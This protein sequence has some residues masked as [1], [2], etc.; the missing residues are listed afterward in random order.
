MA[1]SFTELCLQMQTVLYFFRLN[2]SMKKSD[3]FVLRRLLPLLFLLAAGSTVLQAQVSVSGHVTSGVD[4]EPIIGA[5]VTE[6]GTTNGTITDFD[7]NFALEVA[8]DKSM[9]EISYMG[10]RPVQ[11]LATQ[12][13]EITLQEDA[14]QAE[15]LVVTGYTT[16]RK[17]DLTGAVSV[18]SMTDIETSVDNNPMKALQGKIAGVNIS[19]DGSPSGA[20]TVRI[21]GI[22]T[23]NN[24]DPL[25]IIDGVPT[26]SGMHEL[27][28]ADI[29]SMQVLKDASSASIYG[30][31]AANGVII[32]TTKKGK[33]ESLDISFDANVTGSW[34]TTEMQMLNAKEY[35]EAMWR[36]YINDNSN[37]NSNNIGYQYDWGYDAAGNPVLYNIMLP[38]YLD[39]ANTMRTSDTD[40]F[41]EVSKTGVTQNYNLTV[42]KGSKNG[43]SYFSLGYYDNDGTIKNT[44]FERISAR[45]NNDYS[46]F[47]KILTIGEN[48]TVNHTS[49]VQAPSGILNTALQALPIIPVHTVDGEGWGGPTG[50]MNDRDNPV[51]ILDANKDNAYTYWRIF[52][53][54]YIDIQPI[55][56]LHLRSNFG[57][58]Y[59]NYYRRDLIHSYQAGK[60]SSDLN[61]VRLTQG[62][63]MKWNWS[64]TVSYDVEVNKHRISV[65]AGME[66]YDENNIDFAAYREGFTLETPEVMWPNL[67]TG[68]S[69]STGVASGYA[70]MSFF[71]KADYS[72]DNRYLFSATFRYD[73]SSRFGK[74][75]Q[76]A[77][78]PAFSAGWR[79]SQEDF[80]SEHS[81]EV[82]ELKLRVG[83]G[84]TGNQEISNTA[85]YRIYMP[86]YGT[87]DP[88]WGAVDGTAYDITGTGPSV[89]PSGFMLT[90]LAN[91][92]LK[93]ETTTQTNV[94]LD[95]GFMN[96]ALYGT[97]EYYYKTTDDI[98]VLP[99]YLGAIGEGGNHW[100]NGASMLN[101]GVEVSLGYRNTTPTGFSYE[102][103]ANMAYNQNVMTY[104]PDEVVNSY[105]G[106]GVDDNILGHSIDSYYGYIADGLFTSQEEID[107]HAE[108]TG[109]GLGRIKYRD[110]NE[111]GVIDDDDRTWL[112]DPHPD[113]NFGLTLAFGYKGFDLSVFFQGVA[114]VQVINNEKYHTDFW[115][116]QETG[117][118][119]GTRLLDAW[120]PQN[121]DS[122]IPALTMNNN[123]D[124]GRLSTYFI[125]DGSYL[126]LRN[127]QL[128]YNLPEKVLQKMKMKK[129]RIYVSAQNLFTIKSK[130]YTGTDPENSSWGYP[131]P[132][133]FTG[134]LS[135]SF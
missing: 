45:V 91:D 122:D 86:E 128:G 108:Q 3:L 36:A 5:F 50:S 55:K 105:G 134:G 83:W 111:D 2:Q 62:H 59:G 8:T 78:F 126:K 1:Q 60:L 17:A 48:L 82:S 13:G 54:A 71:A 127:I 51:R 123:N 26:K 89:L 30:S 29:E 79:I 33:G 68:Q 61:A 9:L 70:L 18:V 98:L 103:S 66:M 113:F 57:I 63:W 116:V 100:V 22:G 106:N 129:F 135:I 92:D 31:R 16:Q 132:L 101:Q 42:S 38:Y 64:N 12:A 23:L 120:S 69:T 107:N 93:W 46:F 95:F 117:S 53:N 133:T 11:V 76:F 84:Q 14:V 43:S 28:S 40:W 104:L 110:L 41:D 80:M 25:Y 4:N 73:G 87:G 102:I 56:N 94:G 99:P 24:N 124:E 88:T 77:P 130:D 39:A 58:D 27:N 75:N 119:K 21:R 118:N 67:G 15:E 74:N 72:Y 49:E 52:G 90:Q 121:P 37:P 65:L 131:I 109:A 125:E 6:I 32:I 114:G 7:G 44:G 34:Y 35:G 19:T 112:G 97:V 20:S 115:S 47:D 10:F 96:N 85:I 81:Y